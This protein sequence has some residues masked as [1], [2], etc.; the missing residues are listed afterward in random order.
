MLKPGDTH[1]EGARDFAVHAAGGAN[2]AVNVP[3]WFNKERRNGSVCA[4]HNKGEKSEMSI[5]VSKRIS[6]L[7]GF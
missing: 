2:Y 7:F 3:Q 6:A 4:V 5:S 1:W